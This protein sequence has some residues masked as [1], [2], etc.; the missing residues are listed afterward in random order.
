M[1]TLTYKYVSSVTNFTISDYN[2][3]VF[4]FANELNVGQFDVR[5]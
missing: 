2:S 3:E 1:T 4:K 5:D